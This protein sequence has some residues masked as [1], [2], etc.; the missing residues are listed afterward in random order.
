MEA[1]TLVYTDPG[2]GTPRRQTRFFP[3]DDTRKLEDRP[4]LT[5]GSYDLDITVTT[6]AGVRRFENSLDH[7]RSATHQI[8]LRY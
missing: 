1:V 4:V 7:E 6:E 8:V 3:Q 2:D 5:A